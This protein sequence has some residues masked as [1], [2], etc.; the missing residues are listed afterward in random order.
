MLIQG[1]Q[2]MLGNAPNRPSD[3]RPGVIE[4]MR[5]LM[6]HPRAIHYFPD[7]GQID[8]LRDLG[9]ADFDSDRACSRGVQA[10][11]QRPCGLANLLLCYKIVRAGIEGPGRCAELREQ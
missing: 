1:P 2:Y 4:M 9:I 6:N 5:G 11:C 7:S 10:R 3:S 8:R